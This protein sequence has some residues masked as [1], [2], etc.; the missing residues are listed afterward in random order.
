MKKFEVAGLHGAFGSMDAAHVIIEKCSHRLN[1]N[2]LGGKSQLICRTFNIT[3]NLRREI[4]HTTPGHP[5]RWSDKT[6]VLFDN[7]TR[8]LRTGRILSDNI[9]TLL[10]RDNVGS[11][12]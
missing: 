12:K 9:F 3:I 11:I 8:D 1:Q 5:A 2:H 7:L 6:I 10:S 4:L